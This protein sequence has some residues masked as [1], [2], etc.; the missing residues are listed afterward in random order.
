[1]LVVTAPSGDEYVG[2]AGPN[3]EVAVPLPYPEPPVPAPSP[4]AGQ[5][6]ALSDQ[7]WLLQISVRFGRIDPDARHPDVCTVLEQPTGAFAGPPQTDSVS[8]ELAFGR[9]LALPSGAE[10]GIPIVT[11]A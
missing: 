10:H 6:G 1:V 5:H 11:T 2:V 4:P 8:A 9:E 3:G 7:R